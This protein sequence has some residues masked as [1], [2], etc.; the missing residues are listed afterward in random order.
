MYDCVVSTC[1]PAFPAAV[2]R[3]TIVTEVAISHLA[4]NQASAAS[5]A[6]GLADCGL[7]CGQSPIRRHGVDTVSRRICTRC[8]LAVER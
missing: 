4:G 8:W 1:P 2:A 7:L 3:L 6:Y 5:S